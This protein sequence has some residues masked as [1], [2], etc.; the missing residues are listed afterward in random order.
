MFNFFKSKTKKIIN[1]DVKKYLEVGSDVCS[2]WKIEDDYM[3]GGY[4]PV[5]MRSI[6]KAESDR[7][8]EQF[9]LDFELHKFK[10][11]N[12]CLVDDKKSFKGKGEHYCYGIRLKD[13]NFNKAR[14]LKV[15]FHQYKNVK[16]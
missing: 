3:V 7:L 10:N 14:I 8:R 16:E 9:G 11:L 15:R 4:L 5:A 2:S 1:Q 12:L 6:A 13:N